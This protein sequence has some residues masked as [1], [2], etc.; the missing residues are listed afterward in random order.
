MFLTIEADIWNTCVLCCYMQHYITLSLF[1]Y[2][3]MADFRRHGVA[4]YCSV[5]RVWYDMMQLTSLLVYCIL[6]LS[7]NVVA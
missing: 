6:Q 5:S 4:L 3:Y 2:T 7:P 1:D